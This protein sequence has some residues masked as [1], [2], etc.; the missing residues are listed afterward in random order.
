[1]AIPDLGITRHGDTNHEKS[2]LVADS[3]VEV[4]VRAIPQRRGGVLYTVDLELNPTAFAFHPGGRFGDQCVIS[5]FVGTATGNPTS[6]A[7]CK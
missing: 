6:I 4:K 1:L 2:Y 3:A 5:G 7:L